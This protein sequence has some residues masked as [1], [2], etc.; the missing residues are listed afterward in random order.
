M[1]TVELTLSEN[2]LWA[3]SS[4]T[5][6][7]LPPSVTP[8]S[9]GTTLVVGEPLAPP[10]I[11]SSV[12]QLLTADRIAYEPGMP[13]P[14]DAMSAVFARLLADLR[15]PTPCERLTVIC[16]TEWGTRR[17]TTVAT[18]AH[19]FAS[20][21]VFEETAI[22][23]VTAAERNR[24]RRTVVFEFS[25]L[26]TTAS[27]VIPTHEGLRIEACEHEPNLAAA[28]ITADSPALAQLR[29]VL[30]RLLDGKSA[31]SVLLVGIGADPAFL[32][33][34]GA[35]VTEI[36]G[37]TAELRTVPSADLARSKQNAIS[38]YQPT[39]AQ[40]PRNEWVQPLRER[41]AATQPPRSKTPLYL[42]A[43]AA[44]VIS[45]A[46]LGGFAVMNSGGNQEATAAA[47][48]TPLAPPP[49]PSLQ[50]PPQPTSATATPDEQTIGRLRLQIPTG[51]HIKE[52]ST[53]T[54][55]RLELVPDSGLRARITVIQQ[56]IASG[57]GYP[58][59]AANL[60]AQMA[61]RPAGSVSEL[62]RDVV[63]AGRSGLAYTEHPEDGSRVDW[64]VIVEHSTQVSIGCQYQTGG[65][66]SITH[67]CT[68]FATTLAVNP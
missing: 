31:D 67:V 35:A 53:P 7:D 32:E 62:R 14:L 51:W 8:G 15:V 5:H 13:T 48:T 66:D 4:N 59:V 27:S 12:T 47:P 34:F 10:S 57:I 22:R 37:P 65:Q 19:R 46:A 68:D 30:D 3:R 36:C 42:G 56:P 17:R 55:Q 24:D 26:A 1:P 54:E 2:R 50:L 29:A 45:L 28:D 39:L 25:M 9:D 21:V 20:D 23:T 58:Q 41:A 18:A 63:Y 38:P 16:P 11:T 64:H 60:E 61:S 44:A 52:T 40:L 6:A 33:L 49:Q 43:A